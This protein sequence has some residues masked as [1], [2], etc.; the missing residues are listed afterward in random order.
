MAPVVALTRD[1]IRGLLIFRVTSLCTV[2]KILFEAEQDSQK[3]ACP[4]PTVL[5]LLFNNVKTFTNA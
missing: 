4:G 3:F 2:K 5:H 1:V